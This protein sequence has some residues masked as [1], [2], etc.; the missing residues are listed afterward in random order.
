LRNAGS[1]IPPACL[2]INQGLE[3]KE[4]KPEAVG[5]GETKE[6]S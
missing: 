1:P 2:R 6:N 4:I 3:K 5:V